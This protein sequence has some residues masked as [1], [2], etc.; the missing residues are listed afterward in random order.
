MY[1][2]AQ[3]VNSHTC[4]SMVHKFPVDIEIKTDIPIEITYPVDVTG[5]LLTKAGDDDASFGCVMNV[6]PGKR[7]SITLTPTK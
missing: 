5:A 1:I 3:P 4:S 6:T 2:V 7:S